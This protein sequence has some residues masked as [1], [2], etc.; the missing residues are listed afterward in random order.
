MTQQEANTLRQE[1]VS[2]SRQ[3]EILR[4]PEFADTVPEIGVAIEAL[5]R[6]KQAAQQQVAE[7][8]RQT[9]PMAA[10]APAQAGA[11]PVIPGVG[12]IDL[13]ALNANPLLAGL[14]QLLAGQGAAPAAHA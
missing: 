11:N 1:I 6:Y 14:V 9:A 12:Q 3:I 8:D 13:A 4:G 10:A 7:F 2:V 5:E